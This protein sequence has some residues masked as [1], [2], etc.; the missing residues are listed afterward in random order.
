MGANA[1]VTLEGAGMFF[2]WLIVAVVCAGIGSFIGESRGR[3]AAGLW[4]G[5]LLGPI[6][7]LACLFLPKEP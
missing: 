2:I 4:L 3:R 1:S 6:G 7:C 5:L